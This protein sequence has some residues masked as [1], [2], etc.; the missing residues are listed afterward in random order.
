[1][2]LSLSLIFGLI[3]YWGTASRMLAKRPP[4]DRK[5]AAHSGFVCAPQVLRLKSETDSLRAWIL[6]R[7]SIRRKRRC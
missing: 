2:A 1:M 5:Y 7:S 3:S 6:L 4:Q